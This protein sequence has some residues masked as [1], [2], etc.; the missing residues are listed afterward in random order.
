VHIVHANPIDKTNGLYLN[1]E[2]DSCFII[3]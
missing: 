2:L 3:R 1:N